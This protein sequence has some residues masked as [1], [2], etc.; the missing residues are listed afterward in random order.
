MTRKR[1]RKGREEARKRPR[2]GKEEARKRQA[3]GKEKVTKLSGLATNCAFQQVR[4]CVQP[5]R[6]RDYPTKMCSQLRESQCL[7]IGFIFILN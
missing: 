2:K 6:L 7:A 4:R 1:Q 3:K 5:R